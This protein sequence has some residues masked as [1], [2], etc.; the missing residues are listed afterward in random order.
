M[1]ISSCNQVLTAKAHAMYGRRLTPQDYHEL[2]RKQTI[3]EAASYLKQ[4]TAYAPLL[5]DVN[6]NLV[7]RGELE[8]L[9]RRDLFQQYLKFFHYLGKKEIPFYRFLILKMEKEEI[10]SCIRLLNAGRISDYI[11][12]LPDFFAKYASF[13]LYALA[14][15]KN[16]NELLQLLKPTRY[17]EV[18]N[19]YNF[20]NDEKID[21][22]KIEI[23]LNKL[24]YDGVIEV[25][26]TSFPKGERKQLIDS[27]GMQ[28][29]LDNISNIIRLKK[30]YNA[31]SNYI[32]TVLL[33]YYFKVTREQIESIMQAPDADAAWLAA[34]KTYYGASFKK[35][36]YQYVENYAQQIMYSYH[37]HLLRYSGSAPLTVISFIQ[38]KDTEIKNIFHIIEGIRYG[39]KP[40][41]IGKL[42]VGVE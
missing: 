12:T 28:I 21:L 9:L 29:D 6:E 42:L 27:F 23:E 15:I 11:L 36:D 30:Y 34:C 18:L 24:Y 39:L 8:K 35:Y 10:L 40:N 7:H 3:S 32:S 25:I 37:K 17:Y 1:S 33:P 38:L 41:E 13:D 26:K 22:V 14:K 19:K 16:F 4:Q 5:H 2:M 31:N 20:G